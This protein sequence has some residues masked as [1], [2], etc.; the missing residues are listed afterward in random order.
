MFKTWMKQWFWYLFSQYFSSWVWRIFWLSFAFITSIDLVNFWIGKLPTRKSNRRCNKPSKISWKGYN[1]YR[2]RLNWKS[3]KGNKTR[4][5][6]RFLKIMVLWLGTNFNNYKNRIWFNGY[7]SVIIYLDK[8]NNS[9][10]MIN[11]NKSR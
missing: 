6:N 9:V 4:S 3:S 11:T 1:F 8:R 2:K 7:R 10:F 5:I